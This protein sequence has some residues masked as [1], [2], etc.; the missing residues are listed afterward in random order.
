M[1]A[2]NS[3]YKDAFCAVKRRADFGNGWMAGQVDGEVAVG[4]DCVKQRC[5]FCEGT[6]F[7][8]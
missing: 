7:R 5:Q 4:I 1:L 2:I 8:F 3:S 6:V